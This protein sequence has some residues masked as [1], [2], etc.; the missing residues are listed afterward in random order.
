MTILADHV[1]SITLVDGAGWPQTLPALGA[2]RPCSLLLDL[3]VH[4]GLHPHHLLPE[5]TELP[6]D[7]LQQVRVGHGLGL[8]HLPL[9]VGGDLRSHLQLAL[10]VQDLGVE[11]LVVGQER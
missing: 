1:T 5:P 6:E 8:V 2:L 4:P 3:L 9:P 7:P 10:P 11:E